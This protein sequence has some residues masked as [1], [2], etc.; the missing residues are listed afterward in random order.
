MLCGDWVGQVV[1]RAKGMLWDDQGEVSGSLGHPQGT[2][3]RF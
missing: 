1:P 3:G 2:G